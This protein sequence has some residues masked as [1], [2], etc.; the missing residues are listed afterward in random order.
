MNNDTVIM[1]VNQVMSNAKPSN[2]KDITHESLAEPCFLLS[3]AR[4]RWRDGRD[5][6]G[7]KTR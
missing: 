3:Q 6:R 7:L 5:M 4:R 1:A 2:V